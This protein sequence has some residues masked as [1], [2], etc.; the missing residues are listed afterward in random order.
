MKQEQEAKGSK[1]HCYHET[2]RVEKCGGKREVKEQRN[3]TKRT[4]NSDEICVCKLWTTGSDEESRSIMLRACRLAA[5][6]PLFLKS[7]F[8]QSQL[9]P[10]HHSHHSHHAQYR[11]VP[12]HS[13]YVDIMGHPL[14][15]TC[16]HK[17]S[18]PRILAPLLPQARVATPDHVK[19]TRILPISL[20]HFS[21]AGLPTINP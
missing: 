3:Q 12:C 16:R 18:L 8:C 15:L 1:R 7:G 11:Q 21:I 9:T 5:H 13:A 17:P 10:Q 6:R 4:N 19:T 20:I 2:G 14:Q